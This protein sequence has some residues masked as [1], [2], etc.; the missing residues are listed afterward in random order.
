[1]KIIYDCVLLSAVAKHRLEYCDA[2]CRGC[3][4]LVGY[5]DVSWRNGWTSRIAAATGVGLGRCSFL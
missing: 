2:R 5:P 4:C 1:M 3:R